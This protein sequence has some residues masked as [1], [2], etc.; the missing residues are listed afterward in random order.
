MPPDHVNKI[1]IVYCGIKRQDIK[2]HTWVGILQASENPQKY[3]AVMSRLD[4]IIDERIDYFACMV[5]AKRI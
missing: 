2:P 5:Y 1:G 3:K 4:T